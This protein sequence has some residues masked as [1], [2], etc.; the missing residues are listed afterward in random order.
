MT[1]EERMADAI[2]HNLKTKRTCMTEPKDF[3][4]KHLSD[5][6]S[7][8]IN[9]LREALAH[10]QVYLKASEQTEEVKNKLSGLDVWS[11]R[12][13]DAAKEAHDRETE[14]PF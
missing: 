9:L 11:Y 1:L 3:S 10:K 14:L 5:Y 8:D 13:R 2:L 12:L 4:V 6:S 7:E